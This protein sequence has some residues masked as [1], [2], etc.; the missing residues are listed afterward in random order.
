[1]GIKNYFKCARLAQMSDG[2]YCIVRDLGLVKGG[3]GLKH[4]ECLLRLTVQGA[5]SKLVEVV[6]DFAKGLRDNRVP[7]ISHLRVARPLDRKARKFPS[8][9][10]LG[11][12]AA[13]TKSSAT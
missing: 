7:E 1:M 2:S 4:F 12:K 8:F 5:F 9:R 10:D 6:R 11:S 13:R 3:K